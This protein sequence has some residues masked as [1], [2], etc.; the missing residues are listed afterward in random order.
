MCRGS[1]NR[2]FLLHDADKVE[3]RN[4][5]KKKKTLYTVHASAYRHPRGQFESKRLHSWAPRIGS[6]SRWEKSVA[7]EVNSE[8]DVNYRIDSMTVRKS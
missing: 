7:L 4:E 5:K 6:S 8:E 2:K 1:K 3:D